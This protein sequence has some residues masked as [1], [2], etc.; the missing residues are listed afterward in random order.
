MKRI[1]LAAI[2]IALCACGEQ[3]TPTYKPTKNPTVDF[4]YSR[5]SP[6]MFQFINQSSGCDSYKWD[7][8]D[9]TW[10][11]SEDAYHEYSEIGTYTV[12]LTGTSNGS[13]FRKSRTIKV[14]MPQIYIAGYTLYQIPYENKYYKLEFKDDNLLPSEWDFA[15]SFTPLLNKSDMPYTR[16]FTNPKQCENISSHTYYTVTVLR[17]NTTNGSTTQCMKQKLYVKDIL[18]YNEEYI[19]NTTSTSI[20]VHMRYE[21]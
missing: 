3:N 15:T 5:Q 1:F 11:N 14:T 21:Y 16:M 17:A 4:S 20:G 8:G 18:N 7:F 13:S 12:T 19:L 9:G 10:S 6:M 2:I